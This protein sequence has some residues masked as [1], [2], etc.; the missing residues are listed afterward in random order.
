MEY[1]KEQKA[2]LKDLVKVHNNLKKQDVY[3]LD[4]E[5]YWSDLDKLESVVRILTKDIKELN[6]IS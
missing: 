1:T 5:L 2:A 4:R 3:N 6:E